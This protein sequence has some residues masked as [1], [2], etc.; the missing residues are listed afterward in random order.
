MIQMLLDDFRRH[1]NGHAGRK[2]KKKL[3]PSGISPNMLTMMYDHY[4]PGSINCAVT[5]D[6]EWVHQE[7]E[8]LGGMEEHERLFQWYS[9]EFD[10]AAQHAWF[11]IGQPTPTLR[12]AWDIFGRMSQL[13]ALSPSNP[14]SPMQDPL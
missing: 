1:W 2:Q 4:V 12:T 10:Q 5:V 6:A 11:C 3:N 14:W 8:R 9:D 7:R 13:I